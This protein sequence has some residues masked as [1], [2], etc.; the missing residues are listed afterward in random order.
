VTGV[1]TCALPI[2]EAPRTDPKYYFRPY[3]TVLVRTV[4]DGG[5]S[6]YVCGDHALSVPALYDRIVALA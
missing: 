6:F 4:A 1:Q 2:Y 5:E 3:K